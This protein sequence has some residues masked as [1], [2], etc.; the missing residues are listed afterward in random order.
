MKNIFLI[1]LLSQSLRHAGSRPRWLALALA[2]STSPALAEPFFSTTNQ[3]L[4]ARSFLLPVLGQSQV[5]QGQ[6]WTWQA[7]ADLTTEFLV[8]TAGSEAAVL[9]GETLR[10]GYTLRQSLGDGLE[11]QLELPVYHQS[12]GFLDSFIE[13]WHRWFGLPNG[14][15]E[16]APRNQYQYEVRDGEIVKFSH[17]RQGTALGDLRLGFGWQA[18]ENWTL[19]AAALLPTG[20]DDKLTGGNLGLAAWAD[21]ELPFSLGPCWESFLSLGLTAAKTGDVL[22]EQQRNTAGFGGLGLSY[23]Y[24]EAL[25][26]TAQVYAHT[27]LYSDSELR[28][29]RR[30]GV[31]L[32]FGGSYQ[33]LPNADF[34]LAVQEDIVTASSPDFSVHMAITLRPAD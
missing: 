33:F 22:P 10:L 14:G 1:N 30:P 20:D 31:Q 13:D 6:E 34:K 17:R 7:Q 5:L 24:S 26:F 28:A 9:D 23:G 27:A 16:L 8:D 18:A 11:W 25:R 12:G 3:G 15:R 21:G 4:L 29:L 32:A 2:V 19:R